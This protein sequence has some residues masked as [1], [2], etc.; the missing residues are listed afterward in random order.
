M[1]TIFTVRMGLGKVKLDIFLLPVLA[2][3][4]CLG[5]LLDL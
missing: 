4:C 1:F 2:P 3:P 5:Q